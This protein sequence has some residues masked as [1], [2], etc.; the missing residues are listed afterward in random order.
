MVKIT[1]ATPGA[2]IYYTTDGTNPGKSSTPYT[3]LIPVNSTTIIK[4]LVF[5]PGYFTS[6]EG[7][8]KYIFAP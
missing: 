2:M 5:A 4:A 7:T 3:G 6:P 8:A 1:D